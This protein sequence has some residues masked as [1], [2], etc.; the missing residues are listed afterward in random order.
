MSMIG[1]PAPQF[2]AQAVVDGGE[3]KEISLSDYK[4]K[5]V[6][7]FFYPL[8]FTFVC[9][10]ELT[11]FREKLGEFKELG[12]EVIGASVDSVHSHK[13]WIK[14]DLG[15]LG[16][17][18]IGDI[19]KQ[20]SRDYGVLLQDAGIATRGTFII[21]PEGIVQYECLHN[22]NVGRDANEILRVLAAIKSG[23]L[24]SAGWKPGDPPLK[25]N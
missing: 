16:Y 9:P 8:D 1:R 11:Q 17:P 7:L 12:A 14:D 6:V 13:K 21:D 24:C 22:L 3:F 4:G 23:E 19:T 20:V 25:A 18:L 10:T 2:T 15:D 5:F